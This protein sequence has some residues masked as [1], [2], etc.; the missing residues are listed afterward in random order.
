[1]EIKNKENIKLVVFACDAGMGSSA[2]G[3]S[4]LR[5]KF[6]KAGISIPVKHYGVDE[7]PKDV[8]LVVTH[9]DLVRRAKDRAP[10]AFVVGITNFMG[11]P[12]Y[13]QLV[14]ALK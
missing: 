12:E 10:E 1:M 6:N 13:D 14:N 9:N 11:A 4:F 3:A 7:M 2:M 5:S 8:L